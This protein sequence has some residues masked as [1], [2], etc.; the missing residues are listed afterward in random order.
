LLSTK[1][2]ALESQLY[3]PDYLND[4]HMRGMGVAVC[5]YTHKGVAAVRELMERWEGQFLLVVLESTPEIESTVLPFA[6]NPPAATRTE[7]LHKLRAQLTD[8][9]AA[10]NKVRSQPLMCYIT[11][12][13]GASQDA[14]YAQRIAHSL[15]PR[16]AQFVYL[17]HHAA[18]ADQSWLPAWLSVLTKGGLLIGTQY[19]PPAHTAWKDRGG[20]RNGW[21]PITG[22]GQ[23]ASSTTFEE[24][25]TQAA[26]HRLAVRLMHN[27][28]AAQT[29][30]LAQAQ[31]LLATY[32]EREPSYCDEYA[33]PHAVESTAYPDNIQGELRGAY[34]EWIRDDAVRRWECAPAWYMHKLRQ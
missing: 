16:S 3:L 15:R 19:F 5:C 32:S 6:A 23:G 28:Y 25:E 33:A 22:H 17:D 12:A 4:R 34:S 13:D 14:A 31:S 7:S 21:A 8:R 18:H 24:I 11:V 27:T 9:C 20:R 26:W 30:A 2:A 10:S 1:P 29:L